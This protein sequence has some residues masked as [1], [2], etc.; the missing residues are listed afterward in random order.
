MTIRTVLPAKLGGACAAACGAAAA[1]RR[2]Q[3]KAPASRMAILHRRGPDRDSITRKR[4]G[5]MKTGPRRCWL[6]KA[7]ADQP[8]RRESPGNWRRLA[9]AKLRHIALE[10]PDAE[11]SARFFE[12]AFGLTRVRANGRSIHLSDGVMNV[13]LL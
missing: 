11:K 1:S 2:E 7:L 10:V 5:S 13:A 9:M 3:S 4:E 8:A 12:Q 6:G